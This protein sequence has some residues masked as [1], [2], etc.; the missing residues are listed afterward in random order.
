MKG[1]NTK[2]DEIKNKFLNNQNNVFSKQEVTNC[3]LNSTERN[4]YEEYTAR[5]SLRNRPS[6][7]GNNK[8]QISPSKLLGSLH[9]RTYFKATQSF[10]IG[11]GQNSNRIRNHVQLE[12]RFQEIKDKLQ[13]RNTFHHPILNHDSTVGSDAFETQTFTSGVESIGTKKKEV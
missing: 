7:L 3:S 2:L 13:Q 6:K 12:T 10:S 4:Q 5:L 11:Y 9:D 1:F 8:Q